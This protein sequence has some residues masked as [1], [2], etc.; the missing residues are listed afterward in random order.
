MGRREGELESRWEG[1]VGGQMVG[2]VTF[3]LIV[4]STNLCMSFFLF[5]VLA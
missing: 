4:A 2:T 3:S 1:Q 5:S